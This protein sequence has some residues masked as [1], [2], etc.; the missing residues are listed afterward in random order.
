MAIAF[1]HSNS[2]INTGATSL[3]FSLTNTAGNFIVAG[4]ADNTG[5]STNV[6]GITYGGVSLTFIE[7]ILKSAGNAFYLH[8]YQKA[9]AS[10]PTGANNCVFSRTSGSG[11]FY[12]FAAT[13]TGVDNTNPIDN[14]GAGYNTT[15]NDGAG[16]TFTETIT[17][18]ADNCWI[19]SIV[20]SD[21]GGLSANSNCT[22]RAVINGAVGFYDTNAAQT[23]AG[24]KS[25]IQNTASNGS[26]KRRAITVAFQPASSATN[27]T[28][29]ATV[30]ASTFSIPASTVTATRN[31][32]VSATVLSSTFSIP[33]ATVTATQNVT[34]SSTVLSAT[35]SI[36]T[37]T[38][39]ATRSATISASVLSAT[40]SIPTV[41]VITPDAY[42]TPSALSATFSIPSVT[43]E[44]ATNITISA[45]VLSATF[46]IPT[47]TVT[48]IMNVTVSGTVQTA[49]FSIPAMTAITS[50]SITATVLT[51]TFSL[52]S[53]TVTVELNGLAQPSALTATFTTPT[54]T[55]TAQ[56]YVTISSSVLSATFSV[57]TPRKVGGLWVAQARVQGDW[58]P[59]PRSS[60]GTWTPQARAN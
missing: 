22:E 36:P 25:L 50:V 43:V 49:T 46:S 4:C 51:A 3:T 6:T 44:V 52:P 26:N 34:V 55:I 10:L 15:S 9:S 12:C 47:S 23:P 11:D 40:F 32:T 16:S 60:S 17:T 59:E 20:F 29:N 30:L 38:I 7:K 24:S 2:G 33:T 19:A 8:L 57:Q 37:S 13:Y 1:D 58:T 21:Y 45:T 18:V 56:R 31:A 14:S 27:V 5:T 53:R 41:N 28:V 42:I 48:A 39:T 54:P 35:F